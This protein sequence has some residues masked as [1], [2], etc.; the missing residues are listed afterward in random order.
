MPIPPGAERSPG[1]AVATFDR[2]GPVRVWTSGHA[3][4]DTRAPVETATRFRWFSVTKLVTAACV[5][6]AA[7]R[8][9]IDLDEDV[10]ER[11][12]WFRPSAPISAR[13][14]LSHSSGLAKP[15]ALRWVHPPGARLRTPGELARAT[16]ARHRRLRSAPGATA[17]YTNL[18]YLVLGELLDTLEGGHEEAFDRFLTAAGVRDTGFDPRPGARGHEP[19][20]SLRTAAMALLF[21]PRSARLV[22]YLK[23]GW[24][25]L[26]P[27]AIEGRAYGGLAGSLDDLV[28]LGRAFLGGTDALEP[29]TLRE[30]TKEASRGDAAYGLGF[31][32][33]G[34]GWVGHG[35]EAGGF[36]SQL[37]IHPRRGSGIAVLANSGVATSIEVMQ[38]LK[39]GA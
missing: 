1:W 2:D 22:A 31:V 39:E 3:D 10:R 24:V 8:G 37:R 35:G 7:E 28:R 15:N 21:A 16:F 11:L 12:A 14:L 18:G 6:R 23:E 4:L 19:L 34:D 13:Q 32:I 17:L 26:A 38:R 36:R 5:M 30:M 9:R 29:R 20:R 27:F 25:G 33:D